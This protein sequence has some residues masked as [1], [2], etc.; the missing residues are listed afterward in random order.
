M[1]QILR[2]LQAAGIPPADAYVC[3]KAIKKK[4]ADKVASFKERFKS[5]F[6]VVLKEKEGASEQEANDIVEK[7]WTIINDAASYMFCAAHAFSM[8]C[9]SLYGAYLKAHYP[10]EFYTTMLKLYTEKGNKAKVALIVDEMK[11]YRDIRMTP[12]KF[13]QDNRDWY[14]DKENKTISQSLSSI[15]DM[16]QLAAE[17]LFRLGQQTYDSFTSLLRAIQMET[18]VRKNQVELLIRL[19]Y[20]SAFGGSDMLLKVFNEFKEGKNRLTKTLSEKSVTA[21]TQNLIRMEHDLPNEDIP[22]AD[23]LRAE[24]EFMCI[25]LSCDPFADPDLYFVQETD[26]MYGIKI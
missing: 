17:D 14:I 8:A 25:C 15:K 1:E 18:C 5:G 20:F 13:G 24:L 19:G 4:K 26:D 3:C 6:T 2:I 12:G 10:Y 9:D 23:Q 22:I 11:R 16:S 21:R 7:I